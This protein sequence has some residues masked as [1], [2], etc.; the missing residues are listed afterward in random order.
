[1]ASTALNLDDD[2][3][4]ASLNELIGVANVNASASNSPF[5]TGRKGLRLAMN[6]ET[7]SGASSNSSKAGGKPQPR[8][9]CLYNYKT[10]VISMHK[11]SNKPNKVKKDKLFLFLFCVN[12]V[13]DIKFFEQIESAFHFLEIKRLESANA[14]QLFLQLAD[15][16]EL[17]IFSLVDKSGGGGETSN[18][19]AGDNEYMDEPMMTSGGVDDYVNLATLSSSSSSSASSP[20]SSPSSSSTQA[21]ALAHSLHMDRSPVEI[22]LTYYCANFMY[23]MPS[24]SIRDALPDA[25]CLIQPERRMQ[26]IYA[27]LHKSLE[28]KSKL[29]MCG[30]YPK[31]YSVYCDL[32]GVNFYQEVV[33]D[34]NVIYGQCALVDFSLNDF[35]YVN[36]K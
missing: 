21:A 4:I 19:G 30:S 29:Q 34:V 5:K 36:V 11:T 35:D 23:T 22:M 33:W 7:G 28:L 15:N 13:C 32:L 16:R 9:I 26:R 14:Q 27:Y 3:T 6:V 2:E 20:L 17:R 25:C 8:I 18:D 24:L 1:M 31:A 12:Y 10:Y